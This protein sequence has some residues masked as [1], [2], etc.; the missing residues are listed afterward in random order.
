MTIEV[1]GDVF[2]P[3]VEVRGGREIGWG[4]NVG[5][6]L[7]S[8]LDDIHEAVGAGANSIVSGLAQLPVTPEWSVTEVRASFGITLVAGGG[9]IISQPSE[10]ATFEVTLTFTRA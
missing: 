3:V 1:A 7:T 5:E 8:R 9:T 10:E 4:K 2:V 6:L